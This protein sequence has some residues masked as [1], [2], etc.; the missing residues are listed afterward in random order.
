MLEIAKQPD[1]EKNAERKNSLSAPSAGLPASESERERKTGSVSRSPARK[2]AKPLA[3]AEEY[4]E[5]Q[6]RRVLPRGSL[7]FE[8][9]QEKKAYRQEREEKGKACQLHVQ[10]FFP[11]LQR[12]AGASPWSSTMWVV[13]ERARRFCRKAV[14][15]IPATA[16]GRARW[17][18]LR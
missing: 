18:L 6:Q 12:A 2:P 15:N 5:N 8:K 10:C 14:A 11:G 4:A 1:A 16:A 17:F 7:F 13:F 9:Q 3:A